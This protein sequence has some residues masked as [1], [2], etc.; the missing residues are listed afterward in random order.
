MGKGIECVCPDFF[1]LN[2]NRF[3][4]MI[5]QEK[6]SVKPRE[7]RGGILADEMGMVF[8]PSLANI[9]IEGLSNTDTQSPG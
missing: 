5:T 9:P 7:C 2:S 8:T 1:E 4:H 3:N 6:V